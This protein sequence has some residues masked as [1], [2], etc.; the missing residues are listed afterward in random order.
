MKTDTPAL[1][2]NVTYLLV[3]E[4]PK[5]QKSEEQQRQATNGDDESVTE[6]ESFNSQQPNSSGLI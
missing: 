6:S 2:K 3:G 4:V 5:E 1:G